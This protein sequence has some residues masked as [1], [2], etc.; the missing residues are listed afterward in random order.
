M[1]LLSVIC[2][3]AISAVANLASAQ[4]FNGYDCTQDCSGHQAG[5]DWA[6]R[7]GIESAS[8][9]GGNSNSFIEGCQS[10]VEENADSS[11]GEVEE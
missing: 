6:E 9:C 5:Y 7:N 2:F 1:K 4:T 11:D 3:V 10:Y 8:D